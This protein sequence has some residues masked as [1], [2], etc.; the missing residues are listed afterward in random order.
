MHN[1]I[2]QLKLNLVA[3]FFFFSLF[4]S[5]LFLLSYKRKKYCQEAIKTVNQKRYKL[6]IFMVIILAGKFQ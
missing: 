2:S 4:I 6:T 3:F 5:E 1:I